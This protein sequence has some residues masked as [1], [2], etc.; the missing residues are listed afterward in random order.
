MSDSQ[1]LRFFV[2]GIPK[3]GGSKRAFAF[4]RKKGPKAGRLGVAVMDDAG[5]GNKNWRASIAHTAGPLVKGIFTG[6]ISLTVVFYMPRPKSHSGKKG[7]LPSA[8][9]HP[10]NKPDLLKLARCL[11]DALTGIAWNDDSQIVSEV[12]DKT[13]AGEGFATGAE[14]WICPLDD[15]KP[16]VMEELLQK[17]YWARAAA[18]EVNK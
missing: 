5:E 10:A 11:E 14:V 4:M 17:H 2:Y 9:R 16:A 6:P 8:P 13:Y 15:R 3:P 18:P 7:L 12:L 1:G